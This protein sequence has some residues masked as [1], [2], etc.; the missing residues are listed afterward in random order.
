MPGMRTALRSACA[1]VLL[2][3][4]TAPASPAEAKGPTDVT[5]SGPGVEVT[6]DQDGY[7]P[8]KDDVD[9][10]SLT[11]A[12]QVVQHW[13]GRGLA[14]TSGLS[15]D[16]LGPHYRLDWTVVGSHWAV[17]YAYPFAEGGA[18]VRFFSLPG[19]DP[20]GWVRAPDVEQQLVALGAVD[21]DLMP[22][23]ARLVSWSVLD[24]W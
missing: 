2:L 1:V 11:G 9:I 24:W 6:L 14:P 3:L 22:A 18:W 20:G 21:P 8:R 4:V 5:V 12:A 7:T 23:F 16:Q 19:G 17:Q 13:D 10:G 15:L